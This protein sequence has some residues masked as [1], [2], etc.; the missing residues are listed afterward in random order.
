MSIPIRYRN[1]YHRDQSA[2]LLVLAVNKSDQG[3]Y[4]RRRYFQGFYY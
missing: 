3:C 4:F 1:N 2:E